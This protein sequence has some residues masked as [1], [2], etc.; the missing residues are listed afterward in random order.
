MAAT[1]LI[2][3]L[4]LAVAQPAPAAP[5]APETL[6][7][8][9]KLAVD[10][11]WSESAAL[12]SPVVNADSAPANLLALLTRAVLE[13]G[14][15]R[16]ARLLSE[17]GLLRFPDDLRFRRLDLAVLVERRQWNE[18][19]AAAKSILAEQPDDAVAWRQLAAATL[20][21]G[22][23]DDKRVVL[24]AAHLA[25]PD[26]PLIF[27]KH[28]RAQF[29]AGHLDLA[30]VL[31]ER[32]LGIAALRD[33]ERFVRLAVRV[34][35]AARAASLAK[36]WLDRIPPARRDTPL[37]LLEARLALA[38]DDAKTAEAALGRLIDR[39]D[40]SPS[41]LV[42][43]GQLAE[44]RGALGRAEALY[45]QAAEGQGDQARIARLFRARF[46][47]KLGDRTRA[48]QILRTYLAEYPADAY[49]RQL[50]RVIRA[51]AEF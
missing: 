3:T 46:V 34:A 37:T 33:D 12:L 17:R 10:G 30:R 51:D 15:L 49:A 47:A 11:R 13:S 2:L 44:A 14:D 7:R 42:R 16:R 27:E 22:D 48:E 39:G 28:V 31:A 20:A 6:E 43:A 36:R 5:A 26:D 41:V 45:A 38:D 25:L 9:R 35:E 23:D 4:T 29:L 24:E 18:A 8:A 32:A 1:E 21:D 19:A 50:L 40:A